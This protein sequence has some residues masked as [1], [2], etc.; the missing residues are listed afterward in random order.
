M[1]QSFMGPMGRRRR[2]SGEGESRVMRRSLPPPAPPLT[3]ARLC[4]TRR[5][6]RRKRGCQTIHVTTSYP[7]H[8]LTS[9]LLPSPWAVAGEEQPRRHGRTVR[10]ARSPVQRSMP[11]S[12]VAM[13]SLVPVKVTPLDE[14]GGGEHGVPS[15]RAPLKSPRS[16]RSAHA[17][18]EGRR[19]R[20]HRGRAKGGVGPT[21]Q[22]VHV[23]RAWPA[24][25]S[26]GGA[27]GRCGGRGRG[28]WCRGACHGRASPWPLLSPSK[29]PRSTR[30]AA[31]STVSRRGVPR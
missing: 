3:G 11:R 5:P 4:T 15:R 22:T 6:E 8:Q 26:Q 19:W 29:S 24:K 18:G 20:D 2:K 13:A 27:A 31:A 21:C 10:R 30:S 14:V 9:S 12:G 28:R 16:T 1:G 23:T 7:P 25:S 17:S